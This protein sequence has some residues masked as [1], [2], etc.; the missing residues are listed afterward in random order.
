M[1]SMNE[2]NSLIETLPQRSIVLLI[3]VIGSIL[4]SPNIIM[5]HYVSTLQSSVTDDEYHRVR[6]EN[7]RL[8]KE[9]DDL[10]VR[11]SY[12]RTGITGL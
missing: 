6:D 7:D 4:Q 9:V 1:P 12:S 5:R 2:Q 10:K 11:Y 3:S 8:S